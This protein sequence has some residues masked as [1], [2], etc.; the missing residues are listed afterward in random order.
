M[1]SCKVVKTQS[2]IKLNYQSRHLNI[3]PQNIVES[4]KC[5]HR[6]TEDLHKREDETEKIFHPQWTCP[7]LLSGK[8]SEEKWKSGEL[9]LLWLGGV[10]EGKRI[11]IYQI[12]LSIMP[13]IMCV[14]GA[15]GI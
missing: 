2:Q 6:V 7:C 12:A 1:S 8:W 14:V 10:E 15:C 9:N 11:K 4:L 3:S 5:V 13:F